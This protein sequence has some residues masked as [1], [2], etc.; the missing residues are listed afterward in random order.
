MGWIS[1]ILIV[2]SSCRGAGCHWL[3]SLP[4]FPLSP[5]RYFILHTC[6]HTLLPMQWSFTQN[7]IFI[8]TYYI[9]SLNETLAP[10]PLSPIALLSLHADIHYCPSNDLLHR[11]LLYCHLLHNTLSATPMDCVC[12]YTLILSTQHGKIII[13]T[14][15]TGTIHLEYKITVKVVIGN[16]DKT[17]TLAHS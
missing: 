3:S 14:K 5:M 15:W 4:T 17:A 11:I 13:S 8:I 2:A 16:T 10:F 6:R 12:I 7:F 9:I 1:A